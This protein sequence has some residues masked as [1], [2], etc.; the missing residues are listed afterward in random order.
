MKIRA[1]FRCM[2]CTQHC[3]NHIDYRFMPVIATTADEEDKTF[4]EATPGGE[5]KLSFAQPSKFWDKNGK[6]DPG[7]PV[8]EYKPGDYFYIDM[9]PDEDGSWLLDSKLDEGG[10]GHAKFIFR[11]KKKHHMMPGQSYSTLELHI[12]NQRAFAG[13]GVPLKKWKIT[14]TFARASDD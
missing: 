14:F 1:K 8:P 13:L 4:W 6:G 12:D 9:E 5:A 2:D 11:D 3:N 10:R 7:G